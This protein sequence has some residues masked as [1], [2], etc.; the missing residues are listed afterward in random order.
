MGPVIDDLAGTR[1]R[2]SDAPDAPALD[3]L[4][5]RA[6][7]T[8]S[9]TDGRVSGFSGCN[10]LSGAYARDGARLAL[11]PLITTMKACPPPADVVERT[12][13]ERL[14]AADTAWILD[15][16][17]VLRDAA[18]HDV[19][20]FDAVPAL[21]LDG[22]SWHVSALNNGRQAVQS[23]SGSTALT[24]EFGDAGTVAGDTGCNRFRGIATVGPDDALVVGPVMST[25]RGCPDEAAAAQ[26]SAYLAALDATRTVTAERGDLEL[27]DGSGALQVRLTRADGV[28][29]GA[30]PER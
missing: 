2:V 20:H 10:L 18:D 17:L 24:L 28:S 13:L 12:F 4:D 14:H 30:A 7:P 11:G 1:W 27:R 8:L 16:R 3:H 19:L 26:E 9:F 21:V 22:T 23:V 25:R 29:P 6:A 5:E 15:G